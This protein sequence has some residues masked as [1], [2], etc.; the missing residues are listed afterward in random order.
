SLHDLPAYQRSTHAFGAHG[1]AVR[2]C[3]GVELHRRST[4]C[5]DAFFHL[6]RQSAQMKIA[7]HGFDPGVSNADDWLP[8]ITIGEPDGLK[9][10]AGAGTVTSVSDATAAVFRI[11]GRRLCQKEVLPQ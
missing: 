11:H 6:G 9:H 1:F 10:G 3:D 4:R 7:R 2:D 8:E 5:A